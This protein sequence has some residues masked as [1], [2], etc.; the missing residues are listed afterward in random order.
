[1]DTQELLQEMNGED[2]AFSFKPKKQRVVSS[3]KPQNPQASIQP[4]IAELERPLTR[5][6][7]EAASWPA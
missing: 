4:A 3:F 1:M 7:I 5:P 6:K 2:T